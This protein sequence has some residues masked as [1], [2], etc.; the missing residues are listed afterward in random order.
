MSPVSCVSS[1]LEEDE[2]PPWG[3]LFLVTSNNPMRLAANFCKNLCVI[4]CAPLHQNHT[5]SQVALP[6]RS[7]FSERSKVLSPRL[8]SSSYP[9]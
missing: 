9:Q 3:G 6:L 2:N 4:A 1:Y 7:S 8:Q 5:H